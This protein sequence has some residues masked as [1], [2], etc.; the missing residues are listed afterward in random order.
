MSHISDKDLI[1]NYD[2]DAVKEEKSLSSAAFDNGFVFKSDQSK[3][4][5]SITK[6]KRYA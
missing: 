2:L 1:S 3:E 4:N 6:G 5:G